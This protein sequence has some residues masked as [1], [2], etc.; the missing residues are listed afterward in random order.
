VYKPPTQVPSAK[1]TTASVDRSS[2]RKL[3]RNTCSNRAATAA[4]SVTNLGHIVGWPVEPDD[5][6]TMSQPVNWPSR[7]SIG[8]GYRRL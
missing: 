2:A 7:Q 6:A 4:S 1:Q 5:T 8:N 3:S